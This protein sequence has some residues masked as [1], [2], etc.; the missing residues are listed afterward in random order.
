MTKYKETITQ[1]IY[2]RRCPVCDDVTVFNT[3]EICDACNDKLIEIGENHCMKCS[4][5]LRDDNEVYCDECKS[6]KHFYERAYAVYTYESARESIL[7]FK[8]ASRKEYASFYAN[9]MYEKYKRVFN[10]I[11]PD[12]I[13]PVPLHKSRY[14]KRGYNQAYIVARHLGEITNTPVS[15]DIATRV[16]QTKKQK[17]MDINERKENLKKAFI[18]RENDVKLK[19]ILLIDDVYTTGSTVDS[20]SYELVRAGAKS[21]YVF[22][23]AVV[24]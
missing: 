20:L 22:T 1:M 16:K 24:S 11:K 8:H 10:A 5:L 21:V 12:L 7:R 2:P 23:I 6:T 4:R 19:S 13:I 15:D 9:K 14:I 3:V 18:I 17:S